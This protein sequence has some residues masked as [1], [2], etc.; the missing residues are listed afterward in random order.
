MNKLPPFVRASG[1]EASQDDRVILTS[2]YWRLGFTGE[3]FPSQTLITENDVRRAASS[4]PKPNVIFSELAGINNTLDVSTCT[5][6]NNVPSS[7]GENGAQAAFENSTILP[8][9]GARLSSRF[10]AAGVKG[11]TLT[12]Q[13]LLNLAEICSFDTL[14]RASVSKG[15]LSLK[16]SK[17]CGVY[18]STEWPIVGYAFDVGKWKG[19]GYGTPYFKALGTGFLR[20]LV[21]R[22]N[23]TAPS[24]ANPTS[25]NTTI[26]G[27]S[28][29]FPLPNREK[30]PVIYFDGSHDNSEYRRRSKRGNICQTDIYLV[31]FQDM[32]PIVASLGLF[33]G[34]NETTGYNSQNLPHN[35]VFSQIAPLQ[36]KIVF[37]KLSCEA[38]ISRQKQ[39][40]VRIRANEA[41]LTG[42]CND[43]SNYERGTLCP[44]HAFLKN[45]AFVENATQW[46]TCYD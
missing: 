45:L 41:I 7:Q 31:H 32:A 4:L 19:E 35:W 22:F 38:S 15:Q 20:E 27:N 46:N 12:G 29:T 11:L 2:Q 37:E 34:P 21:A 24:I 14:G 10:A 1:D 42:W 44:M 9:L 39:D 6:Y 13:D 28:A 30:G 3:Q 17:F 18:N 25:L 5:K 8:I 40:F 36:G 26:D 16:Q 23:G 43:G 33:N